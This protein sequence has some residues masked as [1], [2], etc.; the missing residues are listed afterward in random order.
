MISM[1]MEL[2]YNLIE[3]F[4]CCI[5]GF[6]AIVFLMKLCGKKNNWSNISYICGAILFGVFLVGVPYF[7]TNVGYQ[8]FL[9]LL[10][11]FLFSV[12]F[13]NQ[14]IGKKVFFVVL[15]NAILMVNNLIAIYGAIG[16]L[17]IERELI[18]ERN[19]GVHVFIVIA[20]KLLLI[21]VLTFIIE[22]NKN[23]KFDYKQWIITAVQFLSALTVGAI[24]VNMYM[25]NEY[26]I[27][28]KNKVFAITLILSCMCVVLCILQH[29]LNVQNNYK[30]ENER[31]KTYLENEEKNI[32]RIEELYENSSIMRH[33]LKHYAVMMKMLINEHRYLELEKLIDG[34]KKEASS[35]MMA[36]YTDDVT[37][38]S[39]LNDKLSMCR[40]YNIDLQML[41]TCKI[42]K[43]LSTNI[44]V[45]LSNLLDN[46]IEAERKEKEGYIKLFIKENG[47]MLSINVQNKIT[48][49]ILENNPSLKTTKAQKSEHGFGTKSVK[50]RVD[51]MDGVY[52]VKE[53]NE[54]F[55]TIIRIPITG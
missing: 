15:W 23:Y 14:G 21:L 42:P 18:V 3:L 36:V 47:D 39:V 11:P 37:L 13:L 6:A 9:Y 54:E 41:I 53:E 17:G 31:L 34:L 12:L 46:A 27:N 25:N 50:K 45:I 51:E 16:L 38:N 48:Q 24:V 8:L 30:V 55:N 2:F 40:K 33:D 19:N 43:L 28:A 49:S 32:K 5:D 44:C 22:F 29:I 10:V 20:H 1:S 26:N 35:E 52:I 4:A 7:V